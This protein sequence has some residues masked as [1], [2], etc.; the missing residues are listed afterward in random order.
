MH[1]VNFEGNWPTGREDHFKPIVAALWTCFFLSTGFSVAIFGASAIFVSAEKV[2]KTFLGFHH[3][4]P[5]ILWWKRVPH[6]LVDLQGKLGRPDPLFSSC[7][8]S[9]FS[10]FFLENFRGPFLWVGPWGLQFAAAIHGE[11]AAVVLLQS[12]CDL[13]PG[14]KSYVRFCFCTFSV[15]PGFS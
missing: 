2:F 5:R 7:S 4:N 1:R 12:V 11:A 10:S 14:K 8:S 15:A 3:I 6:V 13:E 9:F